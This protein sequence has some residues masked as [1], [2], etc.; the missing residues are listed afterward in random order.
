MP[1]TPGKPVRSTSPLSR[2]GGS[3]RCGGATSEPPPPR[4][5]PV[6]FTLIELLVVIAIIGILAALLLPALARAKDSASSLQCMSNQRQI[7]LAHRLALDDEPGKL[8]NNPVVTDWFFRE[9]GRQECW[10]CAAAPVRQ[11]NKKRLFQSGYAPPIGGEVDSA[12]GVLAGT[13]GLGVNDTDPDAPEAR[14]ARAGGFGINNWLINSRLWWGAGDWWRFEKDSFLTEGSIELP[15]LTPVL[16]DSSWFLG[17]PRASDLPADDLATGTSSRPVDL[18]NIGIQ[19]LTIP[20][21]GHRPHPVPR[22]WPVSAPLPGAINVAF[23][24]GHVELVPLEW[25]WSLYW[26]KDY[27]PPAKRPGLK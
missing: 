18:H 24:D 4:T 26:H 3:G 2:F 6:G 20:R 14:L 17:L 21:H 27:V 22:K 13:L 8:V 16:S 15:A 7:V 11:F 10:M 23:F 12:W 9:F 5:P 25:L 19:Y 1:D